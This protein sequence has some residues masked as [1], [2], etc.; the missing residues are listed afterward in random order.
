MLTAATTTTRR[1]PSARRWMRQMDYQTYADVTEDI[2]RMTSQ[3]RTHLIDGGFLGTEADQ[4][5]TD[6][7]QELPGYRGIEKL[8]FARRQL[9]A[10]RK[11]ILG[12]PAY[13]E[14]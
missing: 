1:K 2:A 14:A 7:L 13:P 3:T 6:A 12:A 11:D 8:E 4:L 10:L 9:D 5:I